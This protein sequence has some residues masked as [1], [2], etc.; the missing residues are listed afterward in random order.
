MIK[1]EWSLKKTRKDALR[2]KE[3]LR[4]IYLISELW[5]MDETFKIK[6]N[7]YGEL[8]QLHF[9]NATK[10]SVSVQLRRWIILNKKFELALLET[11]F[12]SGQKLLTPRQVE[13]ILGE[14]G[15]S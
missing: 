12:K 13:I 7:G 8:A 2:K 4:S 6:A 5:N 10:R 15:T 14:F 3:N 11:G 1:N 9:P